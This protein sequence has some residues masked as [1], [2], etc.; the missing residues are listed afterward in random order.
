MNVTSIKGY[1]SHASNVTDTGIKSFYLLSKQIG[2]Q[3]YQDDK[4]IYIFAYRYLRNNINNVVKPMQDN[5][6]NIINRISSAIK[7]DS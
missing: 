3:A 5:N 6:I 7:I 2:I 4:P 1:Q